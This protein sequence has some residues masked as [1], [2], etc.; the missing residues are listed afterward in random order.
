MLVIGKDSASPKDQTEK[1][2]ESIIYLHGCAINLLYSSTYD[3]FL[4]K[5]LR[6]DYSGVRIAHHRP[7][8]SHFFVFVVRRFI[9]LLW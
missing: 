4:K 2:I 8:Q 5:W 7:Y 3:V 9:F 1:D 6:Y